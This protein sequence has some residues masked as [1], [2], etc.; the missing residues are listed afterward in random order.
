MSAHIARVTLHR[1]GVERLVHNFAFVH[2][3][4][5][6]LFAVL[7]AAA[8]GLPASVYFRRRPE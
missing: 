8:C 6:G 1:A 5:Y 2:P 7:L 4:S 3:A